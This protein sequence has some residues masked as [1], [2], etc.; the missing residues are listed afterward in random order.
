[1]SEDV[2][3]QQKA[4]IVLA[5]SILNQE[6]I[7]KFIKEYND[8]N[9]FF[10]S[11]IDRMNEQDM[12]VTE[13]QR[14]EIARS[15]YLESIKR[16]YLILLFEPKKDKTKNFIIWY[17]EH[18]KRWDEMLIKTKTDFN[19]SDPED[20]R[21]N[22]LK[23]A[24]AQELVHHVHHIPHLENSKFISLKGEP[25][26]DFQGRWK[27]SDG[28]PHG[29]VKSGARKEWFHIVAYTLFINSL[30]GTGVINQTF[31]LFGYYFSDYYLLA[32]FL[33]TYF[34]ISSDGSK[35]STA[36]FDFDK[37]QIV[38]NNNNN[39]L[40]LEPSTITQR[41]AFLSDYRDYIHY[42]IYSSS[43]YD[44]YDPPLIL[45]LDYSRPGYY[46]LQNCIERTCVTV[47]PLD[48]HRINPL[49]SMDKLARVKKSL[50]TLG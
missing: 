39:K 9:L 33:W 34:N 5:K 13:L 16:N 12:N 14:L 6:L 24:R 42:E 48:K 31:D 37:W 27:L 44:T 7:Q 2:Q 50:I 19:I 36:E 3:F 20:E 15:R 8:A 47:D 30:F 40:S 38:N 21:L 43:K 41:I 45:R 11:R 46:L 18:I 28:S 25:L 22:I 1:M 4:L 32:T 49:P 29:D 35:I 10:S 17:N 23:I 26:V